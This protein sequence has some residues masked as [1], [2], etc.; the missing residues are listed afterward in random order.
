MNPM[1]T[2]RHSVT[3]AWRTIVKFRHTPDQLLDILLM[4]LTFVLTFVF[5]FGNA[6]SGDWHAY[7]RFVIPGI[8]IQA[9]MFA[10]LGSALALNTDLRDGV[11][12][13]FRSLPIARSAPLIGHILGD[14]VKYAL[15]VV[16]VFAIG[17]ALGFRFGGGVAA[18][19][20]AA[21]LMMAFALATCWIGVLIGVVART[22][23]TVQALSMVLIFPLTFGSNVFVPTAKLPGWLQV[24]VRINPVTQVSD[25]VRSLTLGLPGAGS[26][27][28]SLAWSVGIVVVFA[29]LAVL[30]YRRRA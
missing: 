18:A 10:S 5:L 13:R 15:S 23:E 12:D 25:A 11:Y 7:L 30:A 21:G 6:V 19:A 3:L 16:L 17:T 22:A 27:P 28:S 9:L 1:R 8:A 4:P 2:A 29:P 14:S 26:V 24:W 20:G